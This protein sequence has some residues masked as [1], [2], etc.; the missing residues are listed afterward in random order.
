MT[1][2]VTG[3]SHRALRESMGAY[4]LGQLDPDEEA[5]L[6]A[7]LATCGECRFELAELQPVAGALASVRRRPVTAGPTP[8]ELR[9]RIEAAIS[10]ETASRRR[11]RLVRSLDTMAAA[12][13]LIVVAVLGIA[14]FGD[15]G[16]QAPVPT[17]V[18]V[19]VA[20]ELDDVTATAGI[21]AHTWG[22]EVKLTTAGL[23]AGDEYEAYVVGED[24]VEVPAGTF[25]AIGAKTMNCNL[26]AS[27]LVDDAS[28]FEIRDR[29]D[30]LVI[31]G[32]F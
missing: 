24:G 17:A 12:A 3:E 27:L 29:Q 31:S 28:G 4:V 30:R 32:D 15:D 21:I 2:D 26:Q 22:V 7:H 6:R 23:T 13:A 1:E 25:L 8:P 20:P 9:D 5:A 18:A 19:Q 16:P 11:T 10:A 14:T